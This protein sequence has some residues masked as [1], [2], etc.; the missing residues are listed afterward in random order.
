MVSLKPAKQQLKYNI[1]QT[2][3]VKCCY[4]QSAR[5]ADKMF[6]VHC[7]WSNACLKSSVLK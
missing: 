7:Q 3:F 5:S 1:I 2:K 4:K 6:T